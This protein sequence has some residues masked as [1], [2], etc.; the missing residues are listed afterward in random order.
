MFI[1][2]NKNSSNVIAVSDF[3]IDSDNEDIVAVEVDDFTDINAITR[4]FYI[5]GEVKIYE[6][7]TISAPDT[8]IVNTPFEVKAVVPIDSPDNEV[9]FRIVYQDTDGTWHREEFNE[10][11]NNGEAIKF[12]QFETAGE[13][14]IEVLS[15]HHGLA[16][17]LIKGIKVDSEKSEIIPVKPIDEQLQEAQQR[18]S[19]LE[20]AI[21]N[22]LGGV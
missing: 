17:Q 6:P 21:A 13:Y 9:K 10:V 2:F 12:L 8:V 3:C 4:A 5:N 16:S 20:L 19:D 7:I 22:L 1:L 14:L 18:I 11:V 15:E